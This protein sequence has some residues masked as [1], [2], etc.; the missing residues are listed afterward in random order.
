MAQLEYAGI[1]ISGGKL[2]MAVPLVSALGGALWA[3]F[4]FYTDYMDMREKIE[5]YTA[6]DLS[7]INERIAVME[8]LV[9]S[10]VTAVQADFLGMTE[11][12]REFRIDLAKNLDGVYAQLDNQD[13]RNR[14][15]VETVRGVINSFEIRMDSK[16]GRLE[17]E[18]DTLE[19][20][21]DKK[22]ERALNNPLNE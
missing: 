10:E 11:S 3:G 6:P 9:D 22:I 17:D 1:K 14:Q 15:N 4:E 16:M 5:S 13:T 7:G 20:D 19:R 2:L 12:M 21:L 18:I 8:T